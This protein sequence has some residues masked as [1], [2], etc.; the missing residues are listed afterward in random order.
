MLPVLRE[1]RTR[2]FAT[3]WQRWKRLARKQRKRQRTT[4]MR[5][6]RPN[7]RRV[8]IHRSY[9]VEEI[10]RLFGVH[11]NTVYGWIK[12][13]LPTCD[14]KRPRLVLGHHLAAFLRARRARNKQPC[15]P[16]EIDCVRCRTPKFPAGDMADYL[17]ITE[18]FGNLTAICPDC[19]SI[20]NQRVSAATLEQIYR[21]MHIAFPQAPRH[22]TERSQPTVN[23]DLR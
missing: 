9:T 10:A 3:L 8:K 23:R 19:N 18:K 7:Y 21:K 6:C 1:R 2:R 17:P 13:G 15:R 5:K 16:G 22:I 4:I 14:G 12:D 20:I 11:K